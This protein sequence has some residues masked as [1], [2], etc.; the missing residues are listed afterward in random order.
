MGPVT[1][2]GRRHWLVGGFVLPMALGLAG[3]STPV[4]ADTGGAAAT[5][6][7][8]AEQTAAGGGGGGDKCP[9]PRPPRDRDDLRAGSSG[10]PGPPGPRGPRGP[11]GDKG[12]PGEPGEQG[13][14]GEQ[15]PIGPSGPA[16]PPGPCQSIDSYLPS[17]AE[18]FALAVKNGVA[19]L[20]HRTRAGG[21][22]AFTAYTWN[23]L[24]DGVQAASYPANVC[25]GTL[26]SQGN[27]LYL[28]VMTTGGTVYQTV[29][30]TNGVAFPVCPNPWAQITAQ[31]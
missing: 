14:R 26:A 23:P 4:F 22:G 18:E 9:K 28:K 5:T 20:G 11:K 1:R 24:N 10:C 2:T 12:D 31:P 6:A 30:A 21:M 16:G 15:G 3:F 25:T 13:E 27:D 17:N 7:A 19:S 29:C 8:V